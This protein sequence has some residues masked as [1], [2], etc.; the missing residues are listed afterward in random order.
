MLR[1][2]IFQLAEGET[3]GQKLTGLTELHL[4][5]IFPYA[6]LARGFTSYYNRCVEV[7][8]LLP[9]SVRA[10]TVGQDVYQTTLRKI[11]DR[12]LGECTCPYDGPCKHQAALLIYLI[13][14]ADKA[15]FMLL[16]I[17]GD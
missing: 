14:D 10:R 4:D 3:F 15:D 2:P 17:D 5:G 1:S 6:I 9:G 8:E 11:E 13:R 12:I 7:V 16:D